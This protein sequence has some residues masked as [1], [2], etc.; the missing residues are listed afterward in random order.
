[1]ATPE[2]SEKNRTWIKEYLTPHLINNQKL[3][4]LND[5][6]KCI[7]LKS[8]EINEISLE[9]AFMFSSCY[10]VK[11]TIQIND[12]GLQPKNGESIE[13]KEFKLVVKVNVVK[14]LQTW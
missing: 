14:R 2:V 11:L 9:E 5:P 1:M 3:L 4:V 7:E 8:I 12:K 6:Q 10:F 13:E